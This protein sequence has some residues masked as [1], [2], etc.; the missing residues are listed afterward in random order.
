[1]HQLLQIF[2]VFL[3]FYQLYLFKDDSL[4]VIT[5]P[6][7]SIEALDSFTVIVKGSSYQQCHLDCL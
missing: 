2:Q 4:A 5:K 7:H 3:L 1:M 6:T